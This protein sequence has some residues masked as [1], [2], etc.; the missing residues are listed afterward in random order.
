MNC[1]DFWKIYEDS[2]LTPELEA[3]LQDCPVCRKEMET[4]SAILK[5]VQSLPVYRAPESLWERI[6]Q[7]LPARRPE[8]NRAGIF[9]GIIDSYARNLL[10]LLGGI[11]LKPVLAGIV[12]VLLSVLA[13]RYYYTSPLSPRGKITLQNNAA[14][15]LAIKE[16]EYLA[17]I[18]K[19][20]ALVEQ[21][22]GNIDPE[23]YDLYKEKLAVL[24]QYI[25]QC[26]EALTGNEF[27][28]NAR[29]YLALA[30]EEKVETLREMS[31]NTYNF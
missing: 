17:A 19:L 25:N 2:G 27:N 11:R 16:Q 7:E 29:K 12:I 14:D 5:A 26:K 28:I 6:A 3:H 4:E 8:K 22:K 23:L 21:N 13:T 20:S 9:T 1:K 31:E 10:S 24:D 15:E 30:Y 18:D